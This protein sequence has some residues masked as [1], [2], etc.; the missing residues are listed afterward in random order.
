MLFVCGGWIWIELLKGTGSNAI[1]KMFEKFLES[2]PAI[3]WKWLEN[4]A[5]VGA[6]EG[7]VCGI[8]IGTGVWTS[9]GS[10]G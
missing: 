5:N 3:T 2:G 7:Y 9:V 1:V 6:V 4:E 8:S 10:Y